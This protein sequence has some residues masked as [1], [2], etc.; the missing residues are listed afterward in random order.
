[1]RRR[2]KQN[3]KDERNLKLQ[4]AAKPE[5]KPPQLLGD[6]GENCKQDVFGTSI[7]RNFL[8]WGRSSGRGY[9]SSFLPRQPML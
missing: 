2:G 3:A 8:S 7:N 9:K 5:K 1:M 4:I 6:S